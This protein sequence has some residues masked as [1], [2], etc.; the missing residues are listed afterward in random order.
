MQSKWK[1]SSIITI[2]WDKKEFFL[3]W[4]AYRKTTAKQM[5]CVN[6]G[7]WLLVI[8][9]RH[10]FHQAQKQ[11]IDELINESTKIKYHELGKNYTFLL[12]P[13]WHCWV[14]LRWFRDCVSRLINCVHIKTCVRAMASIWIGSTL[15]E[16]VWLWQMIGT[17]LCCALLRS[18]FTFFFHPKFSLPVPLFIYTV[19]ILLYAIFI[20]LFE[21]IYI[22]IKRAAGC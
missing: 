12:D 7:L 13:I 21:Q 4:L 22:I 8:S 2:N 14:E 1:N 17:V 11:H 16:T 6:H 3:Y 15:V 20:I 19:V 10:F 18:V 9:I 5:T